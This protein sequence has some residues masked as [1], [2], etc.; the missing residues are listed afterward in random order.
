MD[1][2]AL[3]YSGCP[4][5]FQSK[6]D[7]IFIGMEDVTGIT[8]DMVIAGKDEVEHER[9]FLTFMEMC[10]SNNLTLNAEKIQSSSPRYLSM[11]T[12]HQNKGFHQIQRRLRL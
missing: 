8:D 2:I 11:D 1:K 10:M 9:N 5:H 4:G 12:A 7:A 3:G 6:L